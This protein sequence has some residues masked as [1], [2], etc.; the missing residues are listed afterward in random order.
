MLPSTVTMLVF[1]ALAGRIAARI[2]AAYSLAIGS[3]FAGLSYLWLAVSHAHVYDMLGFSA[4]QGIGFGVAYAALG[5]TYNV[6]QEPD[7]AA[8]SSQRAFALRDRVSERERFYISLR[9]YMDVLGDGDFSALVDRIAARELDPYAAAEQ[10][11]QRAIH[12]PK[13]S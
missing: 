2:G 9:Y 11:L 4:V 3:V 6:A 13:H 5:I 10:L 8:Q 1:S 12:P 7:L